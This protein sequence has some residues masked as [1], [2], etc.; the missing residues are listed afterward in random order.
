MKRKS[1]IVLIGLL[2]LISSIIS[3]RIINKA[4]HRNDEN[5][6][7]KTMPN[8]NFITID[9]HTIS[10]SPSKK[11]TIIVFFNSTCES[12][13]HKITTIIDDSILVSNSRV[14]LVSTEN[15][16]DLFSFS[17][18]HHLDLKQIYLCKCNYQYFANRFG[19]HLHYPTIFIYDANNNLIQKGYG[20]SDLKS[21][22]QQIN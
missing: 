9:G 22:S 17:E 15:N 10:S 8:F 20:S 14:I 2:I 21:F 3:F 6:R 13:T 12:C 11:N 5:A 18:N 7:I 16:D 19:N 4:I 1:K